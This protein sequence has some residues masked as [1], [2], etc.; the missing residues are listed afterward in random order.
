MKSYQIFMLR[1]IKRFIFKRSNMLSFDNYNY[2]KTLTIKMWM[3]NI[4]TVYSYTKLPWLETYDAMIEDVYDFYNKDIPF[5]NHQHVYDVFQM[6]VLLLTR[7]K[8][9]LYNVTDIE[10]FTFCIALLC[11]DIDHKGLTNSDIA[12][13]PSI[14]ND[15]EED[16][17][18]SGSYSSI[19][20]MCSTES[21]NERHHICFG[22]KLLRKHHIEYDEILFTKLISFTDLIIHKKFLE[23]SQFQVINETIQMSHNHNVLILLM[24]LA[25][26]GHILRP[27]DIHLDFV[28]SMNKERSFPLNKELLAKDTL[29]FNN[30]FVFPLIEKM[31][32]INIGLHHTLLKLYKKNIERWRTLQS[33]IDKEE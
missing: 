4:K 13:N 19:S 12:E 18:R 29:E 17:A 32:E 23:Q 8:H 21:Y 2:S 16:I 7:N 10:I 1:F 26:I 20:S 3:Q 5:H 11:H 22:K 33:F 9:V 25:D 15:S 31:K 14:Y 6:G 24:K 27:W 28:F 30:M